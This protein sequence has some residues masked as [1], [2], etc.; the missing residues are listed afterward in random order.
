MIFGTLID[1]DKEGNAYLTD[2]G[3]ALLPK[4]YEAYKTKHLGS[5]AVKWI[6]RVHDYRSPLRKLPLEEKIRTANRMSFQ[7]DSTKLPD[8][9]EMK[10]AIKEYCEL[11]YDALIEQ[12]LVM[13]QKNR[14]KMEIYKA[15]VATKENLNEMNSMEIELLKSVQELQK[16]KLLIIKDQESDNRIMGGGDDNFSILEQRLR[17]ANK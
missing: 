10:E 8:K 11:Q 2:K 4:M 5:E 17:L 6:V 15:M 12:Y 14:E 16:I 1:I 9:P 7:R 13:E 3:V